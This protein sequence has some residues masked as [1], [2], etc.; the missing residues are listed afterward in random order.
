MQLVAFTW[1]QVFNLH[2]NHPGLGLTAG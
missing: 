1:V 2:M